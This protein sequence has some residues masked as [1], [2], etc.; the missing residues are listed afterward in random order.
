MS[1]STRSITV[2]SRRAPMF[3]TVELTDT[4]TSAIASIA[5]SL[6]FKVTPSVAISATYCLISDASGSVRMRR[7]SSRV[8][9]LSSTRIG[10]RPCSSGKRSD[11]LARWN[12]PDAMNRTWSV[13]TAPCLVD[14]VV[15]SISGREARCTPPPRKPAP[16]LRPLARHVGARAALARR[17][18]VDLVEKHDAVVLDRMDRLLHQLVLVEQLVGFLVDQDLVGF[19]HG[20]AAGLGALAEL[21]ENVADRDRA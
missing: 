4:A 8:S 13:F 1:S 6:K 17:D 2:C 21:A 5:S 7:R 3:S 14:T 15:P 18:L 9:G 19:L 16:L 12:A 20:D 11:G 10:S